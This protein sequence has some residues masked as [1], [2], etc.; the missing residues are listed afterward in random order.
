MQ[1]NTIYHVDLGLENHYYFGSIT[2]IF[3]FLTPEILG[4]CKTSLWNYGITESKPYKNKKC[5]IYKGVI[6]R[7]KNKRQ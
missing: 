2:A 6:R 3:D 5:T 4:V 7:T 1:S